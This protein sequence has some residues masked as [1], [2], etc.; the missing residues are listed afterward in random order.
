MGRLGQIGLG[1]GLFMLGVGALFWF[2]LPAIPEASPQVYS[3]PPAPALKPEENAFYSYSAAS[4]AWGDQQDLRQVMKLLKE[5]RRLEQFRY[6]ENPDFEEVNLF[7]SAFQEAES[8][9]SAGRVEP[10]LDCLTAVSRLRLG[11]G[12][13]M[14]NVPRELAGFE[15]RLPTIGKSLEALSSQEKRIAL[16]A[17]DRTVAEQVALS[18]RLITERDLRLSASRQTGITGGSIFERRMAGALPLIAETTRRKYDWWIYHVRNGDLE[19]L[20]QVALNDWDHDPPSGFLGSE[21]WSIRFLL[22]PGRMGSTFVS[23]PSSAF[24]DAVGDPLCQISVN[25]GQARLK[26]EELRLRLAL[27]LFQQTEKRLPRNLKELVELG[28]LA[29]TPLDPFRLKGAEAENLPDSELRYDGTQVWSIGWDGVDQEGK[30]P[31]DEFT[32]IESLGDRI[33]WTATES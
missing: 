26:W 1:I 11:A 7:N 23:L 8:A 17:L 21:L 12:G 18:E 15:D 24:P 14:Y 16:K 22:S 4:R 28:Y 25:H 30:T 19:A 10:M 31:I 29:E 33:I 6:P 2:T 13:T 20:H 32:S 3:N 5:G 9:L 27:S